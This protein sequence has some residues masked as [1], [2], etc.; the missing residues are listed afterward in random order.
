MSYPGIRVLTYNIHGGTDLY[1]RDTMNE[2]T[3]FL[4]RSQAD[5]ITLQEVHE[6]PFKKSTVN[7]LAA[8]LGLYEKFAGNHR[9]TDGILGNAVL[10]RYPILQSVNVPLAS[11]KEQRGLLATRINVNQH[12][13]YLLTTHLGLN[14]N[15]RWM[16]MQTIRRY[17]ETNRL[18][19][20][21][22][23]LTGDLN[24]SRADI[25]PLLYDTAKI[26]GKSNRPTFLPIRRRLDYIFVNPH[27]GLL[28]YEIIPVKY[29]D[30]LPVVVDLKLKQNS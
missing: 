22:V 30:H 23:I 8:T 2:I 20:H 25:H 6:Y 11:K 1:Y 5:F 26:A 13:L 19:H 10:S 9:M 16:Q 7:T 28:Q 14:Q 29:S 17:L 27:F 4:H 18:F 24:T 3:E 12:D 15:E 21:P